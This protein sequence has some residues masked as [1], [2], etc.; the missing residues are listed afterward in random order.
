[1]V[2]VSVRIPAIGIRDERLADGSAHPLH[3]LPLPAASLSEIQPCLRA[4][5]TLAWGGPPPGDMGYI[6]AE[7]Y[8]IGDNFRRR[9]ISSHTRHSCITASQAPDSLCRFHR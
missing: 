9:P 3:Q 6:I 8:N 4:K 7:V 1:M 2:R 5:G